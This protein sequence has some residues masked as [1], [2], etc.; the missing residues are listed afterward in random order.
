MFSLPTKYNGYNFRSRTEARWAVY[1]DAMKI[2]YYYEYEDYVLPNGR[3]YLPDFFLPDYERGNGCF[4]EVKGKFTDNEKQMCYDLCN[5]TRLSVVML[6]G[7]P[8]FCVFEYY[9]CFG[10]KKPFES[11]GL[12]LSPDKYNG[13]RIYWNPS[14]EGFVNGRFKKGD[15][16]GSHDFAVLKAR[17]AQFEHGAK[18]L[19]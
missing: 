14:Y 17:E 7:V 11:E 19:I 10:D 3:R 2:K 4:V 6:E 18:V 16:I 15:W 12:F 5:L 9:Q 8:D 1:F 13:N